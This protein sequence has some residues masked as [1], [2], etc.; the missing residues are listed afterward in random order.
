MS[1]CVY[2]I[3]PV[4]LVSIYASCNYLHVITL[5]VFVSMW[6]ECV[7]VYKN[8]LVFTVK[9]KDSTYVSLFS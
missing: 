6:H 2:I 9:E 4:D 8:E 3:A 5:C 7:S 1:V